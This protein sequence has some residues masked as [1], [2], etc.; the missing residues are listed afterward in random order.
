[1][2][3]STAISKTR[4][5]WQQPLQARGRTVQWKMLAGQWDTPCSA[6]VIYASGSEAPDKEACHWNTCSLFTEVH[7]STGCVGRDSTGS[8]VSPLARLLSFYLL[9]LCF[10]LHHA[11]FGILVP[12]LG[13]ELTLLAVKAESP[14]H[15]TTR[16]FPSVLFRFRT[17][18]DISHTNLY[19]SIT[20][21]GKLH[22]TKNHSLLSV[23]HKA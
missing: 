23:F 12:W 15:W 6:C 19:L 14:N 22:I 21:K 7:A 10:W 8:V 20:L 5:V 13:T 16:E 2:M 18:D 3:L 17:K 4:A 9:L 11:A 1:M